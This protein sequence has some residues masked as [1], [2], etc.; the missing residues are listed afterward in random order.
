MPFKPLFLALVVLLAAGSLP[1]AHARNI[2]AKYYFDLW[3]TD[4]GLPQNSCSAILQTH[5][6]YLW[7]ATA[8]GLVRYDGAR[9]IV[10]NQGN[11]PGI[12]DNRCLRLVEDRTGVLWILNQFG[13]MSYRDGV[14]Q[15]HTAA[16]GVPEGVFQFFEDNHDGLILISNRGIFLWR[17]GRS[18]RLDP[19]GF[20]P[21][22]SF[23]YKDRAAGIWF[24]MGTAVVCLTSDGRVL[25]Y[26]NPPEQPNPPERPVTRVNCMC[27]D[28]GGNVWFGTYTGLHRLIGERSC[29]MTLQAISHGS[30]QPV[31]PKMPEERF[32]LVP[33]LEGSSSS[34]S[35]TRQPSR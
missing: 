7:I 19:E 24:N 11:T 15:S 27:E 1:V 18:S 4:N 6:G 5:D 10:F 8:D 21:I 34:L 9:F 14:F 25:R 31:S 26:P 3:T 28:S 30:R 17:D 33:W 13:L 29:A 32:G 20:V 35:T 2:N 23:G 16:N 12:I 22:G